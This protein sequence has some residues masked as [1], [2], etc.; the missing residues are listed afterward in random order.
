ML[1]KKSIIIGLVGLS[2]LGV[3]SSYAGFKFEGVGGRPLGMGGAFVGLADDI[4]TLY[5]NP[6]GLSEIDK[7]VE[8]YMYAQKMEVLK[9]HYV[10]IAQKN[11][12]FSFVSQNTGKE[13]GGKNIDQKELGMSESIFGISYGGNIIETMP[14]LS[15]GATLKV[16]NL[17]AP[18]K[19]GSGFC[20]DIGA[21]YKHP[22]YENISFGVAIRNIN[23]EVLD[24]E[25]DEVLCVGGSYKLDDPKVTLVGDIISKKDYAK[26]ED[27]KY[28]YNI[29][30]EYL[31][32]PLLAVRCGLADGNITWGFGLSQDKWQLDYAFGAIDALK[33]FN[34][35]YISVSL[36]F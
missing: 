7:R 22:M 31:P 35:H 16:L 8:T 4:N 32:I 20:F 30:L 26:T 1:K 33:D 11:I 28:G 3:S 10:G 36:K 25:I 23:A 24:E 27:T 12:G 5:Y 13:L 21:L 15:L 9:Y 29:G 19:S 6:A 34:N 2:M 14:E 17:N 18:T